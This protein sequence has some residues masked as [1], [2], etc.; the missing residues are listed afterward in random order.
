V[1]LGPAVLIGILLAG[2]AGTTGSTSSAGDDSGAPG[3]GVLAGIVVDDAIRPIAAAAVNVTGAGGTFNATTDEGGLFRITGLEPG[4][5]LVRV[6]KEYYSP[7]EQ[8]VVV[9]TG[10]EDPELVRFQLVFEASSV[11]FASVYKY[12]GFH[13]CGLNFIRVCSNINIATWIV[14]CGSTGGAVCLGNVTGDRSLF[15]VL[16]DGIPS[17]IQ[18][19]LTWEATVET[20]RALAFVIGGGNESE[21]N[22][23]FASGYNHTEGESPLMLRI[24]NH[25]GENSWCYQNVDDCEV[26][27]TLNYTRIGAER[28]LLGQVDAGDSIQWDPTCTFSPC[29]LGFSVQQSF[30]MFTTVFYGYEPP[31]EWRFT[32]DGQPPP[33][34]QP[35]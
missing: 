31:E 15:F 18:A 22:S 7:H 9:Q 16:I 17:F 35:R 4:A 19:E 10:V 5:Y 30:T 32:T 12:E 13:E 33:P 21:L 34:P 24:T 20:G 8:A 25:E 11:P 29:E 28:A 3:Q 14:V 27:E 26:P 1:R 6:S 23:G 2:C